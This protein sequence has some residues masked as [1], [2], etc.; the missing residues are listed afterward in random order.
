MRLM[1]VSRPVVLAAADLTEDR[2]WA[3]DILIMIL[4]VDIQ[5][6]MIVFLSI[7]VLPEV[8]EDLL[9]HIGRLVVLLVR[10]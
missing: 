7:P 2:L 6:T 10:D 5:R 3:I 4:E 1:P 9:G 8:L